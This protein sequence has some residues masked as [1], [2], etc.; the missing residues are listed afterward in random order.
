MCIKNSFVY[1][2]I[3]SCSLTILTNDIAIL[4]LL[5]QVL[6]PEFSDLCLIW[7]KGGEGGTGRSLVPEKKEHFLVFTSYD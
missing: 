1:S 2:E 5:L 7:G 3:V 6:F 4:V